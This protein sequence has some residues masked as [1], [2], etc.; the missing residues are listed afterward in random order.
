MGR[1]T[2]V[3]VAALFAA[4][5]VLSPPADAF[6]P[7]FHGAPGQA[8]RLEAR[9]GGNV[10]GG[11]WSTRQ[12][13]SGQ[14]VAYSPLGGSA[15]CG[16]N[17]PLRVAG[18]SYTVIVDTGSSVLAVP[19]SQCPALSQNAAGAFVGCNTPPDPLKLGPND[20]LTYDQDYGTPNEPSN[21]TAVLSPNTVAYA[22]STQGPAASVSNFYVAAITSAYGFFD[23]FC[24]NQGIWGLGTAVECAQ[25]NSC[26]LVPLLRPFMQPGGSAGPGTPSTQMPNGFALQLCGAGGAAGGGNIWLGGAD[27]RFMATNFSFAQLLDGSQYNNASGYYAVNAQAALVDGKQVATIPWGP[28]APAIVDSGTTLLV[29]GNNEFAT[30]IS[31]MQSASF[32]KFGPQVP[33]STVQQF[34]Q[35]GGT[36]IVVA[37]DQVTFGPSRLSF[38][39]ASPSGGGSANV[40][41]DPTA[42]VLA[43]QVACPAGVSGQSCVEMGL[44]V[45]PSGQN[46]G[47]TIFGDPTFQSKIVFFDRANNRVGFAGSVGCSSGIQGSAA[48]INVFPGPLY[49]APAVATRTVPPAYPP[50][51]C[52]TTVTTPWATVTATV[53][54]TATTTSRPGGAGRGVSAG[55]AGAMGAAVLVALAI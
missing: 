12:L 29:F 28:N 51:T 45:A 34:W 4:I 19:S 8:A 17:A 11:P 38:T 32:V 23:G 36:R 43:E 15:D 37:C 9:A 18:A 30:I 24:G 54:A 55:L 10:A 40:E 13:P 7:R 49:T 35:A 6:R 47:I 33:A 1:V 27:S 52:A 48:D 21:W 53:T 39:F 5:L 22:W 41:I 16:Y 14:S 3:R 42:L 44:A 20:T 50:V 31:A 2:R 26:P 46:G 25:V